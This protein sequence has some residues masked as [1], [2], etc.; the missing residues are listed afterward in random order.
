[1][2][3]YT[4]AKLW[5]A[6]AGAAGTLL[7][8]GLGKTPCVRKAAVAAASKLVIAKEN[9]EAA[10]QSFKDDTEDLCADAREDARLK[11]EA[12]AK[13]AE[14]EARIRAEIEAEMAADAS[15]QAEGKAE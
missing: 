11:A 15:E 10:V 1:M 8:Q 12:A 3:W 6:V 9:A 2:A 7:I 13:A 14:I 4:S 5:S